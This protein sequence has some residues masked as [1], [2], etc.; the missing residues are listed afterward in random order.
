MDFSWTAEQERLH[1]DAR[2]FAEERLNPL[3]AERDGGGFLSREE[4]ERCGESGSSACDPRALRRPR[5]TTRSRSRV[6]VEGFARGCSDT[7]LVFAACAHLFAVRHADRRA[8]RARS[9]RRGCFPASPAASGSGPTR[10][11]R[12]RRART[13][14]RSASAAVRDGDRYLLTGDEDASSPTARSPTASS[15]TPRPSRRTATSASAPSWS[16]RDAPGLRAWRA[17]RQDRADRRT[18]LRG[19]ARGLPRADEPTASARRARARR[20]S[21]ARWTGSARACSRSTSAC[22][23]RQLE[24][25]VAFAKRRRQFGKALGRHQAIAHR[26]ADMKLRL[27]AG[28]LLLHR[29][30]WM[31][32]QG[33]DCDARGR[34]SPS[35]RSAKAP[36]APAS[37]RSRSSAALGIK[38]R[39]GRRLRAARR[40]PEHRS[41]PGTSEIQRDLI[42]RG[43][44]L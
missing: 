12:P 2:R 10:S 28:R 33:L 30:C 22:M 20:S 24:E 38:D 7:G 26:V 23:D 9:S 11:R 41:S 36:S 42:A 3:I 35:S 16:T 13:S 40:D 8:R 21:A 6:S 19:A 1:D 5:A 15:S 29:A 44:G 17:L 4:W 31:K 37:T 14:S 25:V 27:D 34:R 18:R 32:S 39:D 43:L